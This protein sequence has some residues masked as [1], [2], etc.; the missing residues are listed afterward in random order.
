M[1]KIL[2]T[3]MIVFLLITGCEKKDDSTPQSNSSTQCKETISEEYRTINVFDFIP[4]SPYYNQVI[5]VFKLQ[6]GTTTRSGNCPGMSLMDCKNNL[7]ILNTTNKKITY[8]FIVEYRLNLYYW[9]Y[10][11]QLLLIQIHLWILEK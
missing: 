6:K 3:G 9:S 2:L 4:G 8:S 7:S 1:K 11:T 5:S 10:Q